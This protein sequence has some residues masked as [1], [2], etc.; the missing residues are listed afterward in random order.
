MKKYLKI[1]PA[2]II[3]AG[4][5]GCVSHQIDIGDIF[6]R[7]N[8]GDVQ[9]FTQLTENNEPVKAVYSVDEIAGS[10]NFNAAFLK[11]VAK[12]NDNFVI[13][14]LSV[15]LALNMAAA[16]AGENSD[17]ERELLT[18]FGYEAYEDMISES[19]SLI[20]E[21]D[22]KDGSITVN[23]S[24]WMS[25]NKDDVKFSDDYIGN[26]SDI[27][28]AELFKK[29]LSDKK[30]V[31]ELNGWID[32]KTNGLIP[33]MISQPFGADTRMLLVNTL[34]FN[35]KWQYE[36]DPNDTGDI[37]FH[38]TNGDTKALGMSLT[39]GRLLYSE[40][41][42][43][44]SV[45]LAYTDGSCMNIYLPSDE[46]KNIG[47]VIANMTPGKLADALNMDY[48]EQKVDL[49]LPR[50]ECEYN[51]SLRYTLMLLGISS[52]FDRNKADFSRM[53]DA[54]SK[55]PVYIS[56]VIHASK[57]K[58][59]EK[60]TEAAAATIVTVDGAGSMMLEE[61]PIYFLENRPFLYEIKSAGGETLFMGI[62]SNL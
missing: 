26:T 42:A 25:D 47:D 56:D 49:L 34:Y 45:S 39:G 29:D 17:T 16:G 18:L 51:E 59:G 41:E 44:R 46:S 54:E 2:A 9:T 5:S 52:A 27:F 61:E 62:I 48:S 11:E 38:G 32:K 3:A 50:F 37:T 33:K 40:G 30:I 7:N 53:L 15:K 10:G 19:Q 23:N 13:S 8:T 20:S 36:F 60:G 31:K 12:Q 28:N 35:N 21:L 43:L 6:S 55:Y 22:R 57:I 24:V 58:C 1:I 4:L 14:P